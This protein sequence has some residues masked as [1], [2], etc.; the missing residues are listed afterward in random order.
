MGY[1][2]RRHDGG[3]KAA[4]GTVPRVRREYASNE[5]TAMGRDL[6][7]ATPVSAPTFMAAAVLLAIGAFLNKR[8]AVSAAGEGGVA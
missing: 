8:D 6:E 2:Q 5:G 4:V 7:T 3:T 1:Q